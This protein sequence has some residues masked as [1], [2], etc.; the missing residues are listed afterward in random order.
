MDV[1]V[2][3]PLLNMDVSQ[4]QAEERYL[5]TSLQ[6]GCLKDT[7]IVSPTNSSVKKDINSIQ[8]AQDK[9]LLQMMQTA[10]QA[11]KLQRA[12]DLARLLQLPATLDAAMKLAGF[13][14][15]PGLQ[16]KI[17][18]VKESMLDGRGRRRSDRP[19]G[20]IRNEALP[21]STSNGL[22]DS[23]SSAAND[24]TEFAPRPTSARRTAPARPTNDDEMDRSMSYIPDTPQESLSVSPVDT[25]DDSPPYQSRKR[26]IEDTI[27][28]DEFESFDASDAG[29]KRVNG[30]KQ[31][32]YLEMWLPECS[33]RAR[34]TQ[35][36]ISQPTETLLPAESRRRSLRIPSQGRRSTASQINHSGR[37]RL[38]SNV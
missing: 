33:F 37:A 6:L 36:F 19:T 23:R 31:G 21:F 18:M 17:R 14:K 12:L 15:F 32:G 24:L 27:E 11:D 1:D 13:Y 2:N 22:A 26:R 28:F 29:A 35:N 3:L 8:I 7:L 30:S 4:G 5:R 25:R 9:E 38:S 10:C 16:D 34:L 20:F